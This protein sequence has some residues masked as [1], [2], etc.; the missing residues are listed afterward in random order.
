ML[1]TAPYLRIRRPSPTTA[2][3]VVSTVPPLTLPLR[4]TLAAIYFLRLVLG[5]GVLLLLYSAWASS[6]Y[7]TS[8][9]PLE[10]L[11][12]PAPLSPSLLDT[13]TPSST[14]DSALA[15]SNEN[16]GFSFLATIQ[17]ILQALLRSRIG[18]LCSSLAA[19][20]PPWILLPCSF[21]TLYLLSLRI[22]VEERLLVL[23]GLGIQTSSSGGTIF[24][25]L[26][27]RFIPTDKIQDVLI[28]EAF[29]GF[30]VRHILVVIVE[31]EEHVVVVFPKLLPRPRILEKV[32][33]GVRECLYEHEGNKADGKS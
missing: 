26:K 16:N 22:G 29:R 3:F 2:E 15:A 7:S 1:T 14:A 24:S 11:P 4:I 8:T 5:L 6:P 28:N 12:S 32:W 21:A 18:H 30:E 13:S 33:R 31:G 27:T 19:S 23:R 17:Q 10:Q 25:F 9:I 20:L